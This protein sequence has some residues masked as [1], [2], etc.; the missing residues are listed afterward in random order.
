MPLPLRL[1]CLLLLLYGT[2]TTAPNVS[3]NRFGVVV[4]VRS[5]KMPVSESRTLAFVFRNKP[6]LPIFRFEKIVVVGV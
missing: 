3:A 2:T 4:V 1:R 6:S 5:N